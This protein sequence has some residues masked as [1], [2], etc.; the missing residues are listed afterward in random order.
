MCDCCSKERIVI[1]ELAIFLILL[2]S[3]FVQTLTGFG[4]AIITAPLMTFVLGAKDTVMLIILSG[5]FMQLLLIRATHSYGSYQAILPITAASVLGAIPGAYIMTTISNDALRLFIGVSLLVFSAALWKNCALPFKNTRLTECLIGFVAGLLATT[6]SI[7]G[8]I[9]VLY[10]LSSQTESNKNEFRANL[11]RY[12][13]VIT[14]A[15]IIFSFIAGNLNFGRLWPY[16][17]LSLP[18]LLFGFILGDKLFQKISAA[19]LRTGSLVMV[20]VSS[21]AIILSTLSKQHL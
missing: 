5:L 11:S 7:N 6:T 21:L 17:L 3:S 13:L 15:S 16:V 18:A 12:F 14:I 20:I 4:Y 9:I 1:A 8:P 10:Y 2:F 19:T